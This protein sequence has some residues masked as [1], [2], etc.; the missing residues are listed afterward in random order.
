MAAAPATTIS[1]RGLEY[2]RFA[3]L[4]FDL[5]TPDEERDRANV[6]DVELLERRLSRYHRLARQP[7]TATLLVRLLRCEHRGRCCA[8]RRGRSPP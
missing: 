4:L 5:L 3:T 1:I 2:S 8:G 7:D 6:F